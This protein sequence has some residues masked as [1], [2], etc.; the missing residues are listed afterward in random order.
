MKTIKNSFCIG[1]TIG[2][3]ISIFISMIFSNHE[4]HPTNP[5]STIGEWYY[6]SFTEAQIMLIMMILWGIIGILFQ[7]GAKI[8]EY[9]DTSLTKRTLRH[10]SFMFL[11][12]LPLACLA[13][14]FPLKITAFVFFAI[15]YSF[16]YFIIWGINY[17]IIKKE[18]Q[19]INQSLQQKTH[20]SKK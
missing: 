17:L 12:F 8:F 14:W 4:Y 16:I 19:Q 9:D 20:T 6:Q 2:V 18:I 1:V 5:I 3:L 7:W 10:F 13:G 11:L 15:I